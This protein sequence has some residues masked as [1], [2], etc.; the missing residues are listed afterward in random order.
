MTSWKTVAATT[1]RFGTFHGGAMSMRQRAIGRTEP[2]DC[3]TK[4]MKRKGKARRT[5]GRPTGTA[6]GTQEEVA[7]HHNGAGVLGSA[8]VP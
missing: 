2:G 8:R 7:C 3:F 6:L 5:R 4:G 1:A